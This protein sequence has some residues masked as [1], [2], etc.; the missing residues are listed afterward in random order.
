MNYLV[1]LRANMRFIGFGF[2]LTFLSSYGQTF[3]V[4]L[5]GT[6]IR[7]EFA[8]SHGEFGAVFS[9]GSIAAAVLLVWVGRMIDHVDLRRYT[10]VT[11]ATLTGAMVLLSQIPMLWAFAVALFVVR[12]CGQGL[13]IHIMGTSMARYFP[14]D[15][16]KALS[17]SG[18]GLAFGEA[19]LPIIT[20][21]LIAGIGWRNVW[22]ATAL[23]TAGAL[24]VLIP[25]VLKDLPRR[26]AAYE[27]RQSQLVGTGTVERSWTRMQVLRDPR[28][29]GAM[30]LLLSYPYI[31]T[32]LLFHQAFIAESKGWTI[33]LM[34]QGLVSLAVLKVLTSLIIGPMIDRR[35]AVRLIP[36]TGL[37]FIVTFVVL[38]VSDHPAMPFVFFGALG[39]GI[40][41]L[42]PVMSAMFAEMYG[43]ANL[44]GIRAMSVSAMVLAAA[45]APA[46]FGWLFDVDVG[47]ET[48]TIA[49]AAYVIAAGL[50][51][52]AVLR[53]YA[54]T[55]MLPQ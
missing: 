16:G 15:R 35:G 52:L 18:L 9:A 42:Q 38:S 2:L 53:R 23:V 43:T 40:G 1:F 54:K 33:D 49:C 25:V 55:T 30:V 44:G 39:V 7:A 28:Y 27:A 32:G 34:A 26:H 3:Y 17:A 48:V 13:C 21:V 6:E 47:V 22:L 11:L 8:L 51:A 31:S 36:A 14:Q 19:V 4:A 5:Y 10:V 37:P 45:A 29:F 41:M 24:L 20:V 50:I 46:T 12:M